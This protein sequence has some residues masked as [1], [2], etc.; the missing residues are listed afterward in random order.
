M[1]LLI[2]GSNGFVGRYMTDYAVTCGATV[3]G[4]SRTPNT[5]SG[6]KWLVVDLNS[7]ADT[8]AAV[9]ASAA[10]AVIH[11][12]AHTPANRPQLALQEWLTGTPVAT[13]NL[14]EA[15]RMHCPQ[16]T[17]LIVSSSAV[18]GHVSPDRLPITEDYPMQPVTMYGVSKAIQELLAIRYVSEHGLR[19]IRARPFNLVGPGEPRGML[20]STLA[21]QIAA[22]AAG[23]HPSVVRMRHRATSR[24]F[25]D[26]RD[27]VAAYW[28]L[29]EHGEPG[30]V[31]NVCSGTAIPVGDVVER[32]L[33]LAGINA[34]VEETGEYHSGDIV[35][36]AGSAARLKTATGWQPRFDLDASLRD[37]L[38]T[39]VF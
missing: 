35:T 31:Y 15:V 22:I 27:A 7:A 36:Q 3:F 8:A 1:R 29:L 26:V 12:A 9:K 14:L 38:A 16:A 6:D 4:V 33:R 32:L 18:Y 21:A 19:V 11:L 13:L 37:L 17:V 5:V 28:A 30:G 24:D 10:D 23:T 34:T 39:F 2:T 25:T 20:T